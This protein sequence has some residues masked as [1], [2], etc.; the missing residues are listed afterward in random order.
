VKYGLLFVFVLALLTAFSGCEK[1]DGTM[2][3]STGPN[4][5]TDES[6]SSEAVFYSSDSQDASS[7]SASN[8]TSSMVTGEGDVACDLSESS[9]I[10]YGP[11]VYDESTCEAATGIAR[12][13][14]PSGETEVCETMG[15]SLYL[16]TDIFSCADL[17]F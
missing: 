16:Y 5:H 14:C 1:A 4:Y 12:A 7:S 11:G 2:D 9:S 15:V 3:S 13:S 17:Q 10:C 6:S 8:G